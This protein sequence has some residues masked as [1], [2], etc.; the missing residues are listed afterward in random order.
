[1]V[2]EVTLY[3]FARTCVLSFEPLI[4]S[5]CSLLNRVAQLLPNIP[6]LSPSVALFLPLFII[7]RTF[8]LAS[9]KDKCFGLTHDGLSHECITYPLLKRDRLFSYSKMKRWALSCFPSLRFINPYP[10]KSLAPIHN[11][12]PSVFSTFGQN[13]SISALD[14][15]SFFITNNNH[16]DI[17]LSNISITT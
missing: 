10:S 14:L 3:L 5:F 8:S 4:D 1:M 11:Q 7:S 16:K 12:H 15:R 6:F 9:P 2:D 17:S 13:L